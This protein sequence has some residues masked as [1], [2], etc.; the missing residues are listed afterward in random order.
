MD[1]VDKTP[2]CLADGQLGKTKETLY[3]C[4]LNQRVF[5]TFF[6]LFNNNT[7]DEVAQIFINP[8]GTSRKVDN[9]TLA[10]GS[11]AR[12]LNSG[13]ILALQPGDAIEGYSTT[14]KKVDYVISGLTK[15]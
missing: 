9:Y 15:P 3:E 2:K 4:P 5:V 11:S 6:S 1:I 13:E 7:T 12:V 14:A 10:A 8:G